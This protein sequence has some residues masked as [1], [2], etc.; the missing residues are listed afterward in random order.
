[1]ERAR[2]ARLLRIVERVLVREAVA[3]EREY[4]STDE[5]QN[6][7]ES[8]QFRSSVPLKN[9]VKRVRTVNAHNTTTRAGKYNL[10]IMPVSLQL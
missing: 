9:R 5:A 6:S 1:M 10:F 2:E 8:Y 4:I 3:R 7:T